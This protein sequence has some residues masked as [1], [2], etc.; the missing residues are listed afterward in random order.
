MKPFIYCFLYPHFLQ[1]L[2]VCA[3]VTS[4]PL[5]RRRQAPGMPVLFFWSGMFLG[6]LLELLMMDQMSGIIWF[7]PL[8]YILPL[9]IAFFLGRMITEADL[10]E[11]IYTLS[12][13]YLCQH[14]G[15]CIANPLPIDPEDPVWI[16]LLTGVGK[17]AIHLLVLWAAYRFVI[18]KL[19]EQGH[20]RVSLRASVVTLGL[21]LLVCLGLNYFFRDMTDNT[22]MSYYIGFAYDICCCV[23]LLWLQVEQRHSTEY[24]TRFEIE[25]R[26]RTQASEQYEQSRANVAMINQKCHDIK[27]H[28]AA[29]RM[30][31]DPVAREEGLKGIEKAVLIYDA[32]VKTGNEILDTVLTEKSLICEKENIQWTCMAD[33]SILDFMR[34]VDL[35][36][37]FGNALDNSIEAC[38]HIKDPEKRVISVIVRRE[39]GNILIQIENYYAHT[40]L[41]TGSLPAS[42]KTDASEHGYG[43]Q[44]IQS[45]AMRYG[46]V[47]DLSTEGGIFLVSILLPMP[48]AG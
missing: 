46:G 26:L 41:G 34:A 38:R 13:A 15:F 6:G 9:I 12:L 35:Y 45:I 4:M 44:S 27:H 32:V 10:A 20:F 37:L 2:L 5:C 17:W 16:E 33:G 28:V 18:K 30:E 31:T 39:N 47:L 48:L 8:Y 21:V 7:V 36:T 29:L 14:I 23:F 3:L 40:L 25:R 11:Q 24:W 19:P 22:G 42:T 1:S 43:L